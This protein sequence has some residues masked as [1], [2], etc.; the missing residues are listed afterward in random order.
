M[1]ATNLTTLSI[2][3]LLVFFFLIY[4]VIIMGQETGVKPTQVPG[5]NSVSWDAYSKSYKFYH[6]GILRYEY[7]INDGD[8]EQ[9]GTFNS[10]KA[11]DE[12]YR[13][14]LPSN[15]GGIAAILGGAYT[16]PWED[17]VTYRNLHHE[18]FD[19]DTVF[20]YWAMVAN[21]DTCKYKYKMKILGRTLIIKIEVDSIGGIDNKATGVSLDRCEGATGKVAPI[22][23]PYLPLFHIL[24]ANDIFTSFFGDWETTNASA[25]LPIKLKD[26]SASSVR[27]AHDIYYYPKTDQKRNR[28]LETLYL[29]TSPNI[30]DVFPNIP[31]P[32]SPYRN[33]VAN[34][35]LWDYRQPF[36]RLIRQPWNYLERLWNAGVNN[37]WVQ[38]HDWQ[39][40]QTTTPNYYTG[41]DDGLPCT[42]P[43]NQRDQTGVGI[44]GS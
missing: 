28:V 16:V 35:I 29:T 31:N 15:K 37:L 19:G 41:Y 4:S 38:I 33:E 6:N 20:S 18:L 14:F 40:D 32:V 9:G 44:W 7:S 3:H 22:E 24:L 1:K 10:L 25:L 11:Y 17:G 30:E 34:N 36:A 21:N 26:Y 43:A 13:T 23:I 5:S 2:I 27:Y 8:T 42:L 39:H 12:L